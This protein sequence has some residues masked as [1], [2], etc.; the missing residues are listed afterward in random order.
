MLAALA[1]LCSAPLKWLSEPA[2]AL[3]HIFATS[4]L[5]RLYLQRLGTSRQPVLMD[6]LIRLPFTAGRLR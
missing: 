6:S 4:F 1:D 2:A 3:F 5:L